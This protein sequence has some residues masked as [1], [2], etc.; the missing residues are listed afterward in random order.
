MFPIGAPGARP[1]RPNLRALGPRANFRLGSSLATNVAHG[2]DARAVLEG[3]RQSRH[4]RSSRVLRASQEWSPPGPGSQPMN[5]SFE[6]ADEPEASM[7]GA[8]YRR[9]V[10]PVAGARSCGHRG[11][12]ATSQP[13]PCPGGGRNDPDPSGLN[14]RAAPS[15]DAEIIGRVPPAKA[16]AGDSYAAEFGITG[17]RNGWFLGSRVKFADYGSGRGD[18]ILIWRS[19]LGFCR[20]GPVCH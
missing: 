9:G 13:A 5:V 17:S 16:Q 15:T 11:I 2:Q 18:R 19:R 10:V 14:I 6:I 7:H 1:R 12:P 4:P 8:E 3:R 20:R